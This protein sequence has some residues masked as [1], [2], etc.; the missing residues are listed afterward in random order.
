MAKPGGGIVGQCAPLN[1]G[2]AGICRKRASPTALRV[3]RAAVSVEALRPCERLPR[4]HSG[5]DLQPRTSTLDLLPT[6]GTAD[7]ACHFLKAAWTVAPKGVEPVLP[8]T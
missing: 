1:H 3:Q 5:E 8:S 7:G 4:L 2:L 6:L